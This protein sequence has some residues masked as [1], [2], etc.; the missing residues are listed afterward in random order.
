MGWNGICT[1][2]YTYAQNLTFDHCVI[3]LPTMFRMDMELNHEGQIANTMV[4]LLEN[5]KIITYAT[6]KWI[7]SGGLNWNQT[8]MLG[9]KE[10]K[11]FD[12]FYKYMGFL[13]LVREQVLKLKLL[14]LSLQAKNISYTITTIKDPMHQLEGLDY[15][16][17]DIIELLDSVEYSN[18]LRFDGKFIDEFLGH[19]KHPTTQEHKLIGDYIWQSRLT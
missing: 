15:I 16:K 19:D 18:W 6:R 2:A 9:N 10:K 1:E 17:D 12:Q 11:L 13:P 3:M 5:N 7:T 14:I 4:D 8:K